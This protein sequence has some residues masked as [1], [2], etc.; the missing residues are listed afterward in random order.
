MQRHFTWPSVGKEIAEHC[1]S[2][3]IC[4]VVT[5]SGSRKAPTMVTRSV[6]SE[7]FEPVA[8]A[9]ALSE[10]LLVSIESICIFGTFKKK[11]SYSIC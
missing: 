4:R 8:F 7:P 10:L 9:V 3:L 5:K 6:L 1:K 11:V 2:C